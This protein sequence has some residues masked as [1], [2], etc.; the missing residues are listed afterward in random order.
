M[1][2]GAAIFGVLTV[3]D[4]PNL[5]FVDADPALPCEDH[6]FALA[7]NGVH[8]VHIRSVWRIVLSVG[9]VLQFI[10]GAD[11]QADDIRRV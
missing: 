7:S 6:D 4:P 9:K 5:H 2:G 11:H 1:Y 8:A 3:P 10:V